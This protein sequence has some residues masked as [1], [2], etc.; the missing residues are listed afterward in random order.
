VFLGPH[1]STDNDSDSDDDDDDDNDDVGTPTL[2]ERA[3]LH[4]LIT[5]RHQV[6]TAIKKKSSMPRSAGVDDP[7]YSVLASADLAVVLAVSLGAVLVSIA[8]IVAL[9]FLASRRRRLQH[10]FQSKDYSCS[11]IA[12]CRS[13]HGSYPDGFTLNDSPAS[14]PTAI[15]QANG[16]GAPQHYLLHRATS[17]ASGKQLNVAFTPADVNIELEV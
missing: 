4:V 17:S 5:G 1:N 16:A 15:L 11:D 6:Q 7:M 9:V 2:S 13:H 14:P 8:V 3:A 12:A 10:Q